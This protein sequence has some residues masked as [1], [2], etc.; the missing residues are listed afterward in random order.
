MKKLSDIAIYGMV[1]FPIAGI[2]LLSTD[3]D[4][5]VVMTAMLIGGLLLTFLADIGL[6][7]R[8][9]HLCDENPEQTGVFLKRFGIYV[10][11]K[12]S[13]V[14]FCQFASAMI[15]RD[16]VDSY[17]AAIVLV[18]FAILT[19]FSSV[20]VLIAGII[21]AKKAQHSQEIAENA[22]K[23]SAVSGRCE[24]LRNFA[25]LAML[26]VWCFI[27]LLTELEPESG[28]GLLL[29]IIGIIFSVV[30][31][32]AGFYPLSVWQFGLRRRERD[33][34]AVSG[35]GMLL[36][37]AETAVVLLISLLL[38]R[39]MTHYPI[40]PLGISMSWIFFAVSLGITAAAVFVRSILRNGRKT[41]SL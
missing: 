20:C 37:L 35:R 6:S 41:L 17:S 28:I 23:K 1:F 40:E 27:M 9:L 4:S 25:A 30:L 38:N 14:V 26:P 24:K 22:A 19:A 16:A 39:A 32:F 15:P 31:T 21:R 7:R 10:L 2:L 34:K 3:T 13:L 11:E 8:Q 36:Y 29:L 18:I 33:G 12:I 5:T